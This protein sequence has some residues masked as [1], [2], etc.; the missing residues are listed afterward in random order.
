MEDETLAGIS[1]KL[2]LILAILRVANSEKIEALRAKIEQDAVAVSILEKVDLGLSAGDL[3]SEVMKSVS[4]K[5]RSIQTRL[6]ELTRAGVLKPTRV[7]NKNYYSR[8]GLV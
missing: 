6:G 4:Q 2:D 3:V 7:G 8:T 1:E 5:E